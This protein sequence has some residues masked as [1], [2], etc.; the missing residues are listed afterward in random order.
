MELGI[1]MNHLKKLKKKKTPK[2]T[3]FYYNKK[4]EI[5]FTDVKV[6]FNSWTFDMYPLLTPSSTKLNLLFGL[7]KKSQISIQT[8]Q[9]YPESQNVAKI[10]TASFS[11]KCTKTC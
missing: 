8:Q 3:Q 10:N 1:K 11:I 9:I 5:V 7:K 6:T 2:N 4:K